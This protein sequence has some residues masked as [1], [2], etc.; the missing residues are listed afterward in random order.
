[1]CIR[2]RMIRVSWLV[3]TSRMSIKEMCIRDRSLI[4]VLLP[5]PFSPVFQDFRLLALT[6]RD[7]V[8][9]FRDIPDTRT[10]EILDRVGTVSYTHLDVYKRQHQDCGG[11]AL[12]QR[13]STLSIVNTSEKAFPC[14]SRATRRL[15]EKGVQC[16][17][18]LLSL[19]HIW[20]DLKRLQTSPKKRCV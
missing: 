6:L 17:V 19:I 16:T 1:M 20:T 4:S 11:Q 3:M 2:D 15:F 8:T 13:H 18:R 7:N 10:K 5:E 12:R 9:C 14:L